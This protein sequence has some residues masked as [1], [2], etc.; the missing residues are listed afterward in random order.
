MSGKAV[1]IAALSG[2]ALA[3]A[4]RRAGYIPFVVDAFGDADTQALAA[5]NRVIP[6][7]LRRGFTAKTLLPALDELAEEAL[8]EG[9]VPV[10]LILGTGFEDRP[11][12]IETLSRTQ[13]LLGCTAQT[14]FACKDP[15]GFFN[16]LLDQGI[17]FPATTLERPEDGKGWLSKRIGGS[18]GRHVRR[19]SQTQAGRRMRYYQ[20]E[21][22]GTIVSATALASHHGTAFAFAQPWCSPTD[23]EP[24]R[25]G[26]I[27]GIDTLDAD[28]EARLI[29]TGKSL[30]E[31]LA[32]IGLVS[33]D[34]LVAPD[35]EAFLI[36]IN[37]RPGASLDIFDDDQGTLFAAHVAA[38]TGR[39]GVSLLKAK[40]AP[41]PRATAYLYADAGALTFDLP[42]VPEWVADRPQPGTA[43]AAGAPIATVIAEGQDAA[44]AADICRDRLARLGAV[45]YASS[46]E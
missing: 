15:G 36:E 42:K 11:K 7:A 12:L 30:V 21:G 14:V 40:W 39:D 25:H 45:L 9:H 37:P 10:G 2:R 20:R 32:L 18:G 6:G 44:E 17:P 13:Q 23:T 31:K 26:G 38:C 35:D 24:F 5:A 46:G 28:L 3:A 19:L 16:L 29:D 43:I 34:F 33:F 41:K 1:L 4:A 22:D 8:C 27:V